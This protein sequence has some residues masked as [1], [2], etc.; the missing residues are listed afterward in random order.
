[1]KLF[2][3]FEAQDQ[4]KYHVHIK[5]HVKCPANMSEDIFVNEIRYGDHFT[6]DDVKINVDRDSLKVSNFKQQD[7]FYYFDVEFKG[8][9]ST[10]KDPL[11]MKP[12]ILKQL[13]KTKIYNVK[14]FLGSPLHK[15]ERTN[16]SEK[17]WKEKVPSKENKMTP[18]QIKKAKA[19]ARKAGRPYP[20]LIDNML[21]LKQA[22]K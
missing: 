1:M 7:N 20:N 8:T 18:V 19:K 3:V 4:Q 11:K 10:D 17:S 5:G 2:D 21:V 14:P 12:R 22:K 15:W 16:E 9:F 13:I 6:L